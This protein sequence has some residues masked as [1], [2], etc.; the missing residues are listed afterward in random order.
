MEED[1]LNQ[2]LKRISTI[3]HQTIESID[4]Q[5]RH[6]YMSPPQQPLYYPYPY[7]PQAPIILPEEGF[8]RSRRPKRSSRPRHIRS[9]TEFTDD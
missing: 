1:A 6:Y 2:K 3:M 9:K 7:I 5:P 8:N 4:N